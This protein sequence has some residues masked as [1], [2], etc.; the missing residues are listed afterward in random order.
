MR[1]NISSDIRIEKSFINIKCK[2]HE[3]IGSFGKGEGIGVSES[4]YKNWLIIFESRFYPVST[5][6]SI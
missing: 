2:T 4:S 3:K 1:E 5:I 6:N